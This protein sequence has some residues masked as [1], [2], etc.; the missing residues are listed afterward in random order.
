V[1]PDAAPPRRP[2]SRAPAVDRALRVLFL[3]QTTPEGLGVSEIARRMGIGKGPCH[4]ILK[5]LE[6]SEVVVC[7][8]ARK[9]YGLGAALLRLGGAVS[10]HR[11]YLA[12]AVRAMEP[13]AA[14]V[15]LA[16]S[17][18]APHGGG[19]WISVARVQSG[20]R[21]RTLLEVGHLMH[22][23]SGANG[24]ALLAWRPRAEA[25]AMARAL[26]LPRYT[27]RSI[28]DVPTYLRELERC[29]QLGYAE[30]FGEYEDGVSTVAAP[31][32]DATGEVIMILKAVGTESQLTPRRAAD[33][34]R[35]VR[36]VAEAVTNEIG[37]GYP[38]SVA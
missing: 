34:G 16:C 27:A 26:G 37:G 18:A 9:R 12:L 31:I 4:A 30:N 8:G 20:R 11:Q 32:F 7:D 19:Q 13:L 35:R 36:E 3:L 1:S 21:V 5:T 22:A 17:L 23:L 14:E 28:T 33:V 6:A 38:W 25:E 10:R 15:D 29:R 2:A 24:K